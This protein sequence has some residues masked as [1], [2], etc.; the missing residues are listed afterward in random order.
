MKQFW[1]WFGI[2]MLI[3]FAALLLLP[4]FGKTAVRG[5]QTKNLS[6]AKQLGLAAR[7]FA[8]DHDGRFPMQLS[9]IVPDYLD[10]NQSDYLLFAAKLGDEEN[11]RLKYDWL[12]FGAGFDDKN[13]PPLLIAF[14]LAFRDDK[15]QKRIVIYADGSGWIVNEEEYQAE[16]RK[17]IEAMHKKFDAAKPPP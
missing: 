5:L 8:E 6:N 16:L 3:G 10:A 14:P 17:T 13:P 7:Q 12:Y 2:A 4:V 9:E 11:P 15:K 1:K